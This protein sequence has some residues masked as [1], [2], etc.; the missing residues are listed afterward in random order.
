MTASKSAPRTAGVDH[1][2]Q[3]TQLACTVPGVGGGDE[4]G[5]G[6]GRSSV[7]AHR[8]VAV[9]DRAENRIRAARQEKRATAGARRISTPAP[10]SAGR[11]CRCAR[12]RRQPDRAAHR[13]HGG[14]EQPYPGPAAATDRVP[15]IATTNTRGDQQPRP[16]QQLRRQQHYY[17][18]DPGCGDLAAAD[19]AGST[20]QPTSSAAASAV[21][22]ATT[23]A[24]QPAATAPPAAPRRPARLPVAA[25]HSSSAPRRWTNAPMTASVTRNATVGAAPSSSSTTRRPRVGRQAWVRPTVR[26]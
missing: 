17:R 25:S 2:S 23:T 1:P 9:G 8:R 14:H 21:A 5:G 10:P 26:W 19:A 7:V 18:D 12:A 24:P 4:L 3:S 11:C 20:Q 15:P 16:H 13:R 22:G 6:R